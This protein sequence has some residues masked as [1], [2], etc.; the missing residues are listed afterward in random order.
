MDLYEKIKKIE[1]LIERASSSGERE[2]ARLAKL[3]L[4][5]RVQDKQIEFRVSSHSNWEKK[6]F[7][8]I[9]RKHGFKPYRYYRQKYTTTMVRVS[10]NVMDNIL[11][12]EYEKYSKLFKEMVDEITDELIQVKL[13]KKRTLPTLLTTMDQFKDIQYAHLNHKKLS[14]S[15]MSIS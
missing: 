12:P 6:L 8:T 13:K 15:G 1:A 11:W 14:F 5:D 4:Q 9:C 10:E 3:R 2:A 7:C